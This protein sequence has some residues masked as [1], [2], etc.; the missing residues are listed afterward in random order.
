MADKI[1][2]WLQCRDSG[3]QCCSFCGVAVRKSAVKWVKASEDK[4]LN[5]CPHCGARIGYLP[6]IRKEPRWISVKDRTPEI[7]HEN[8]QQGILVVDGNGNV[9]LTRAL[10]K[11]EI[12]GEILIFDDT[13]SD[14]FFDLVSGKNPRINTMTKGNHIV[15]WMPIPEPPKEDE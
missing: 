15:Y 10:L 6:D 5:Y 2:R 1:A 9:L 14:C 11:V 8:P 12:Q 3:W 13:H 4:N 7:S